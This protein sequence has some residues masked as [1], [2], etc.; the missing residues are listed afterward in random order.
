MSTNGPLAH[1]ARLA[2]HGFG[3]HYQNTIPANKPV[4]VFL[5]L[6]VAMPNDTPQP[7]DHDRDDAEREQPAEDAPTPLVE[8]GDSV[9]NPDDNDIKTEGKA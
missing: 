4:R 3:P 6:E 7:T 8:D 5:R 2:R 1:N 9:S